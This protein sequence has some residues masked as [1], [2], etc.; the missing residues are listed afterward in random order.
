MVTSGTTV[1]C[2]A[3]LCTCE[4][5]SPICQCI[6]LS[7]ER[8]PERGQR[9]AQ[10]AELDRD[11]RYGRAQQRGA[12]GGARAQHATGRCRRRQPQ[13]PRQG[14]VQNGRILH[15]LVLRRWRAWQRA[16]Q[17]PDNTTATLHGKLC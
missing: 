16:P 14:R 13:Q 1:P 3:L 2:N 15:R 11:A 4:L 12:V 10:A 17:R 5:T 6:H 9:G 8:A 7:G